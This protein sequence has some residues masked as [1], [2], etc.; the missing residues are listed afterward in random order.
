[1]RHD[2]EVTGDFG[3]SS[4]SR[5]VGNKTQAEWGG[6]KKEGLYLDSR[7]GMKKMYHRTFPTVQIKCGFSKHWK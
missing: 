2:R 7:V 1:M 5:V 4:T 3:E 6:W